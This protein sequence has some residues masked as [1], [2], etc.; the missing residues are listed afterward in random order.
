MYSI[1]KATSPQAKS[2]ARL[3]TQEHHAQSSTTFE[4][5]REPQSNG[6]GF[7]DVNMSSMSLRNP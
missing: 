7:L 1:A 4:F 6:A 5:N 2:Q 3:A